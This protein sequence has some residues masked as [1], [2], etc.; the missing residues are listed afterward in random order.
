M[1]GENKGQL[2]PDS[3]IESD[4]KGIAT[5]TLAGAFFEFFRFIGLFGIQSAKVMGEAAASFYKKHLQHRF[6]KLDIG[7]LNAVKL[8]S[9]GY[10]F[11]LFKIYMFFKFFV[12][13]KNVVREGY[14]SH[15]EVSFPIKLIYALAAFFKGVRNN[16]RIFVTAINYALPVI[17]GIVF[18]NLVSFVSQLNFAVSVEYNGQQLGY[19]ENETI[20][21]QAENK[22]QERMIYTDDDET[23][24]SA[25]KFTVAVVDNASL[26]SDTEITDTIIQASSGEIVKG[27]GLTIDGQFYGVVKDSYLLTS[28]LE[29]MKDAYK[30][31]TP[32]EIVDFA[33]TVT[34]EE[35]LYK[36]Q[37]L[38]DTTEL[39]QKLTALEEK[40]VFYEVVSGDTPIM[41]ASKNDMELDELVMLN[42]DILENCKIGKQVQVKRASAFLPVKVTRPATYEEEVDFPVTYVESSKLYKGTS[43]TSKQGVKGTRE[44]NAMVEYVDGVEVGRSITSTSMIAEPVAAVIEKGTMALPAPTINRGSGSSS[45]GFQW[46]VAG[47]YISQRYGGRNNHNGIDYA[48]RGNGYGQPIWAAVPGKV[49]FSGSKGSYGKLVVITSP[50]GIET[51]YAHCSSLLV[52]VGD[53]VGQGQQI[54]RIGSTGNSTGNHLHFRVLVNGAQRNPMNYLP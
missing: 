22:L 5:D 19:I 53:T 48:Y 18:I 40:E 2:K 35:G 41:I 13:A 50:G 36:A 6:K 51:W 29:K 10:K 24:E 32:G 12:D 45:S 1:S 28:T 54:A 37:N 52:S 42:S 3:I 8:I 11:V 17:T 27:T 20:F 30:T 44:V 34:T 47:G 26:K 49:T 4:A 38:V 31:N 7:M 23:I 21:E 39:T 16:R 46:P 15:P 33:R 43:R 25:P 14:R 9:K